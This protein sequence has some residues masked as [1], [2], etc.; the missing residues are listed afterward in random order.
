MKLFNRKDQENENERLRVMYTKPRWDATHA[1]FREWVLLQFDKALAGAFEESVWPRANPFEIGLLRILN[2]Y[3]PE[4]LTWIGKQRRLG[5]NDGS[6]EG[7]DEE[8]DEEEEEIRIDD[9]A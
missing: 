4:L 7:K 5:D 2:K 6:D 8:D 3:A 9:E 1:H